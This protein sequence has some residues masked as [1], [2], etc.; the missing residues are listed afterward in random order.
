MPSDTGRSNSR[1]QWDEYFMNIATVVAARS[2]C[3]RRQVAAIIVV[4]KRIISTGYNGTPRGTKN[5]NEGGCPRCAESPESGKRL[6]ECL[7]S[8]GEENAIVQAAYHG[9][10]VK[11]GVLYSTCSPCLI[12][13]KMIINAGISEVVFNEEYPLAET[14]LALLEEAGV[15]VRKLKL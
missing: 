5:C 4:D 14:S 10:S 9:T 12:C 6:D 2:N 15:R 1:P 13:T 7:C 3:I 11:G 8:H